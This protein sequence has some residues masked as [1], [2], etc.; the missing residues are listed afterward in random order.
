[1]AD[2][3][4]KLDKLVFKVSDKESLEFILKTPEEKVA[5][6]KL[7]SDVLFRDHN[8]FWNN[9]RD[10]KGAFKMKELSED[11][12]LL[13]NKASVLKGILEQGVAQGRALAVAEYKNAG[14]TP[15]STAGTGTTGKSWQQQA[16]EKM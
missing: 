12:H 5:T 15:N 10:E 16:A 4:N 11:M 8:A 6:Q 2:E 9:Y 7:V 3:I 13:K 1:L 14:F